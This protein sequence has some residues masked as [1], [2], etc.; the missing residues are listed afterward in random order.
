MELKIDN[1][2]ITAPILTILKQVK[3]EITTGKLSDI[4]DKNTN[5][6]ITCPKHKDG[7]ETH[8][9]C[10]VY[11]GSSD[12]VE[13]GKA[14]CFTCGYTASLYQVIADCFNENI[15]FGKEWLLERF[16]DILT[17]N[18][19]ILPKIDLTKHNTAILDK[20]ILN[21]FLDYHPYLQQ[22]KIPEDI[23][24]KF[25]VK[26][27]PKTQCI[28]FPVYDEHDNLVML[29]RRSINSKNFYI[30]KNCDKPVYLYNYIKQNHITTVYVTESQINCLTLYSWGFPAI[31]LFGTGSKYQ[32]NI[33]RKAGIRNYILCFDGDEAGDK[34]IQRFISNM[35][36]DIMISIK[37]IPRNKDVNDL[38]KD[39]FI[40]LP[41]V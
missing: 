7:H 8:P 36:K 40:N 22:R 30:D 21:E 16:G 34:G 41:T 19:Q 32:Y 12:N 14:H 31:A 27:D 33:L 11:A 5:I 28:I 10:Q 23:A 3:R 38:D 15:D 26:Y 6:L 17:T 35:P 4:I 24:K 39:T 29:T 20:T 9:S 25:D 1:K 2:I 18:Q 37:K 13:Y